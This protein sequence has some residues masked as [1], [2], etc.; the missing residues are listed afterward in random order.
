MSRSTGS[1]RRRRASIA[2]TTSG[3]EHHAAGADPPH[4]RAEGLD[5]RDALLEEIPEPLRPG[6]HELGRVARLH[7][8]REDED[9]HARSRAPDLERRQQAVVR[10]IGSH[11]DVRD[12]EV[13]IVQA[14]CAH[15]CSGVLSEGRDLEA[16]A[17]EQKR[18]APRA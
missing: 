5:I 10:L 11:A 16:V 12:D 6:V 7:V 3:I 15:E 14:G 9:R 1:S 8:L 17:L 18:Q 2:E 13:G 4:V